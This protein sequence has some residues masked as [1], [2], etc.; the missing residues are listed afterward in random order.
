MHLTKTQLLTGI[1]MKL[2]KR[3]LRKILKKARKKILRKKMLKKM[4]LKT[5]ILELQMEALSLR[6]LLFREMIKNPAGII[7]E[8]FLLKE[9]RI[10]ILFQWAG[11]FMTLTATEELI[12][13]NGLCRT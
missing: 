5:P 1:S 8:M 6:D 11:K 12:M 2:R 3:K 13:L 7:L 4:F 9:H 10:I